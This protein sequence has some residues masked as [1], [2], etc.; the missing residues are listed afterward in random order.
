MKTLKIFSILPLFMALTLV[1]FAQTTKTESIPV[2]GNCG[3]CKTAIEKAAKKAGATAAN[4][5]VKTKTL[6]IK[7]SSATTNAAKIQESIAAAGYDTR[8]L[9]ATDAAYDKL[10]AC[11]QYD[12]ET[13]AEAR[14]QCS[15][16]TK[17]GCCSKA[18]GKTASV[19]S[20]EKSCCTGTH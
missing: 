15:D 1:S 16:K 10:P 19:N 13:T 20:N 2:S 12:R 5:N 7:Y 17:S 6:T 14:H 11:C 8:D 3:M 4:W 18:D 9:K